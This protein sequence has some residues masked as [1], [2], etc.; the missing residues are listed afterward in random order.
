MPTPDST[1]CAKPPS[2]ANSGMPPEAPDYLKAVRQVALDLASAATPK[3]MADVAAVA[4]LA[5]TGASAIVICL[6]AEGAATLSVLRPSKG[7]DLDPRAL[8]SIPLDCELPVAIAVRED[9]TVQLESGV[10]PRHYPVDHAGQRSGPGLAVPIRASGR[11]LGGIGLD[12]AGPWPLTDAEVCCVETIALLCGQAL[13]R[14]EL[15]EEALRNRRLLEAE[16]EAAGRASEHLRLAHQAAGIGTW[17]W[18]I[19]GGRVDWSPGYREIYGL[20]DVAEP[21]LE[22]GIAAVAEDDRPGVEAALRRC[23]DGSEDFH[24]EHRTRHP[25]RGDRWIRG[26]GRL[27]RDADGEPM[28]LVGIVWDAT[29]DRSTERALRVSEERHRALMASTPS[30]LWVA[31][32]DGAFREAQPSWQE[33]TDQTPEE[34]RGWG[35]IAV[36]HPAD[37]DR[38]RRDW[39]AAIAER[40]VYETEERIW[41]ARTR[42]YRWYRVR[43][44]PIFHPDGSVR[45]WV[46]TMEDVHDERLAAG[47]LR[48]SEM[49]FR[50]LVEANVLG[51][52]T[53]DE[54][55]LLD[56]NDCLLA[57]LGYTREDIGAG[58]V[59]WERLAVPGNQE[60]DARV[61]RQLR[62]VGNAVAHE[63]TARRKDDTRVPVLFGA[64]VVRAEPALIVGYV[65]DM[66]GSRAAREA[67]RA[68]EERL[69]LA[70][71]GAQLGTTHWDIP[72]GTF[73]W[74]GG[75]AAFF[76]FSPGETPSPRE[77]LARIHPED[78]P[79]VEARYRDLAAGAEDEGMEYRVVWPN[80]GVHWISA[81]GRVYFDADGRPAR[82][83]GIMQNIDS[84]KQAEADI[85]ALN[86]RLT[87]G[88]QEIHHR[89]KNNL[90]FVLAMV[91]LS[92]RESDGSIPPESAQRIVS[93]VQTLARIHD[94][95]THEARHDRF[96]ETVSV[97]AVI[98]TLLAMLEQ[99]VGHALEREIADVPLSIRR[100][101]SVALVV[102]ELVSNAAKHARR[103]IR[104]RLASDGRAARLTVSDDGAGLPEG[105]AVSRHASTGLMIVERIVTYDL[106][107][108]LEFAN[109]PGGG[110]I[111]IAAFPL[112]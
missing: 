92:T 45:E 31:D 32:P 50:S 37:R 9:R 44:V 42:A 55:R 83:E 59:T 61:V 56:A 1:P 15:R 69:R 43:G 70:V 14:A 110:A 106:Q 46:G 52:F 38:V 102:S 36:V 8:A 34:Y 65:V 81:R 100:L 78:R 94:A 47:A 3:A 77:V 80:G 7:A 62:T 57:T 60:L 99:T 16:R 58:L 90:Q 75:S 96:G 54:H 104:V 97:S 30:I 39:M 21:S 87:L 24:T 19:A 33:R 72:T 95:L 84:R 86:E 27:V 6:L 76:G 26:L 28:R 48:E 25:E 82:Y 13:E 88:I 103:G 12:C 109:A 108:S 98:E 11:V 64:A 40:R 63:R 41:H 35:R 91:G 105:F 23:L 51:V 53:A 67:L 18:D 71:D 107:G 22:A 85:A 73:Q 89:I 111:I 93:H 20:G 74:T 49:R 10:P 68:S 17:E 29:E 79:R 4:L 112:G 101:T 66:S 5:I 2:R